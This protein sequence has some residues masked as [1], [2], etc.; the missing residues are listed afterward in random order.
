MWR[1]AIK[2]SELASNSGRT[3]DL[4]ETSVALFNVDGKF[5]AMQNICIHRGGP[6]GEGS[7]DSGRVTCPWHAW[8][9]DVKTGA[10]LTMQGS[11]LKTYPT[12]VQNGEVFVE[13][14]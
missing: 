3:L 13:I 2:V 4:G 1:L 10:C 7:L 12:K 6:L 8:E 14:C 5:Y 9:F 11:Q